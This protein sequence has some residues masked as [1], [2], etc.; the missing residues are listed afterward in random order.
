MV[1]N[2][3]AEDTY[4]KIRST[5]IM[6]ILFKICHKALGKKDFLTEINI[7]ETIWGERCMGMEYLNGETETNTMASG[8]TG[9][10]VD[11]VL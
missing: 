9:R 6:E 8:L 7:K 4:R 3:G 10:N 2:M 11:M 5:N 1:L